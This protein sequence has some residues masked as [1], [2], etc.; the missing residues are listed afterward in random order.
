M[1]HAEEALPRRLLACVNK[2]MP[3]TPLCVRTPASPQGEAINHLSPW[4]RSHERSEL[5]MRGNN[6]TALR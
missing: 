4:E 3:L 6:H 2:P 5:R 1:P